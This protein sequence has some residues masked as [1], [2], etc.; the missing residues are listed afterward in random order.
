MGATSPPHPRRRVR[1]TDQ[2]LVA[3]VAA[4]RF[5][6]ERDRTATAGELLV[7]LASE[8]DGRAGQLLR[9]HA[10]AVPRLA[11]RVK[12]P[13]SELPRLDAVVAAAADLA[14]PRPPGTADLL[15][16]VLEVG[17]TQA[18]E[19]LDSCGYEARSLYRRA[20]AEDPT[21]GGGLSSETLGLRPEADPDPGLTPAAAVAVA[22]VR[23]AAGGAVDL[24]LAVAE[25][26]SS[27]AGALLPCGVEDLAAQLAELRK[28]GRPEA[29]GPA[30]DG[31]LDAVVAAARAWH[32]GGRAT[33][34]DLLRGAVV[35]GGTGPSTLL[36]E[37]RGRVMNDD[38][39]PQP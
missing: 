1:L 6:N 7:G 38:D 2:A 9:A 27:E 26:G 30:W 4:R 5:A 31:G 13:R 14:S 34:A 3:V 25:S 35:A 21:T 20:T 15:A 18:V 23:A 39:T 28:Q 17:G 36:E 37:A 32:G 33:A 19:L 16:A 8:P 10:N 22:R 24:V 11:E 12:H 29:A